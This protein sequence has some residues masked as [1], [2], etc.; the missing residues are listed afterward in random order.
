[1]MWLL[2]H[3][4][5]AGASQWRLPPLHPILVNFTAA[6]IPVSVLS[7]MLGRFLRKESLTASGWWTL[8]FASV[9]TP[10]TALAGWMWLRS[11]EGMDAPSI[12][13]HKWLGT[14]LAILL[15]G[16]VSWRGLL[17]RR[18]E[19]PG[20]AY[21]VCAVLFVGALMYQGD[22][23]GSM[24]F[25]SA[26]EDMPGRNHGSNTTSTRPDTQPMSHSPTALREGWQ[27]HIDVP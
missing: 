13:I 12:N 8:L 26:G 1:M 7:D 27:D 21:F 20:W 22:L 25:A 6:L 16:L 11:M 17:Y 24:S 18:S 5:D 3:A 23:G 2:L 14:A 4:G 19:T 10:F 9:A 15:L